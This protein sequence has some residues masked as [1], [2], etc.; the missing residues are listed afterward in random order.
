MHRGTWLLKYQH[1]NLLP[2]LFWLVH[3]PR[4]YN[5]LTVRILADY[6]IYS[7]IRQVFKE[8]FSWSNW[9]V[10]L[11]AYNKFDKVEKKG[12]FE[13]ITGWASVVVLTPCGSF[14][15]ELYHYP[16]SSV[17]RGR[18]AH[19]LASSKVGKTSEAQ[20]VRGSNSPPFLIS[21]GDMIN[22]FHLQYGYSLG[23]VLYT[24]D[25]FW[26]WFWRH[27]KGI[28]LYAR[29]PYMWVYMV[30]VEIYPLWSTKPWKQWVHNSVE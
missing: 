1:W 23:V 28:V 19:Q 9:G 20:Q 3:V 22:I 25:P 10:I 4:N 15:D 5:Y 29:S 18:G 13:P 11:Y 24:G 2:V 30:C 12:E 16:D 17:G 26:R 7:H 21:Y 14:F 6:R 8:R 27:I